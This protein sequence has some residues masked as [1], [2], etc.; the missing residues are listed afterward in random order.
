MAAE[1]P[2]W[3]ALGRPRE[4]IIV[5]SDGARVAA[6][7]VPAQRRGGSPDLGWARSG[8][9][10]S[11]RRTRAARCTDGSKKRSLT[12]PGEDVGRYRRCS[13]DTMS[14]PLLLAEPA[15]AP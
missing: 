9:A 6:L 11:I 14:G 7:Q 8:T 10:D 4:A 5:R 2:S 13:N 3:E 12:R 15:E 1:G